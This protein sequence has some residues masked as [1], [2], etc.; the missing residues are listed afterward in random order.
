MHALIVA[1]L[2]VASAQTPVCQQRELSRKPY[3]MPT[4][5]LCQLGDDGL[6]CFTLEEYKKLLEMDSE[7]FTEK[8]KTKEKDSIIEN[9]G[10]IIQQKDVLIT[11]LE[12]DKTILEGQSERLGEKWRD[13]LAESEGIPWSSLGWGIA[14]GVLVGV[15][16]G[17][18]TYLAMSTVRE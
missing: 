4:G 5:V 3:Y 15:I 10:L 9:Q 2:L 1:A 8:E 16:T 7:L 6:A 18:I 13:C 11:T 12:K 17:G 14:A